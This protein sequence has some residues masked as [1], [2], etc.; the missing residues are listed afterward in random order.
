MISMIAAYARGRVIGKEGNLPWR[1]PND[2][3]YFQRVT[4]RHT[5]VMGRK[6]FD[7]MGK[8]LPRRRNIVLSHSQSFAPAGVEVVRSVDDVLALD[9]AENGEIFIVGGEQIYTLF[10]PS[11]RR[12][13]LTEIELTVEGDTHFPAWNPQEFTL[14]SAQAGQLDEKNTLPHTFLVYERKRSHSQ[15]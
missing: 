11:A 9:Q 15:S 6:T 10:L 14:I 12:L 5:V 2:S 1:L 13:Y 8:P 4:T 3:R 7:S